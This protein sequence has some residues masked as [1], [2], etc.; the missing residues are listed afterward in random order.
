MPRQPPAFE[1]GKRKEN[2]EME[3]INIFEQARELARLCLEC[4]Y[5]DSACQEQKSQAYECVKDF[6][7]AD[8]P[9]WD[10][11]QAELRARGAGTA[12][13]I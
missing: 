3:N 8:C 13:S 9:F 11:Y 4:T 5:A 1:A 12:A 6:A 7:E 10:D 2:S